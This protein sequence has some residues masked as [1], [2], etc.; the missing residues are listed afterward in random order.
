M[1]LLQSQ[2]ETTYN[3]IKKD[4]EIL[5]ERI[6][7]SQA[8]L[9]EFDLVYPIMDSVFNPKIKIQK[10]GRKE[11]QMYMGLVSVLQPNDQAP[12]DI[13][14]N[15]GKVENYVD[16]DDVKLLNDAKTKARNKIKISFPQY[17]K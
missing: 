15:I 2:N 11:H 5:I 1:I 7:T 14:F 12:V 4:R 16:M 3:Q 6:K 17:F 10:L 8:L 13:R 9:D